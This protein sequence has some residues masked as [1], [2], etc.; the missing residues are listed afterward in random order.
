MKKTNADFIIADLSILHEISSLSFQGSEAKFMEEAGEKAARLFGLR[1]FA[2]LLGPKSDQRLMASLGLRDGKDTEKLVRNNNVNQFSY[3]FGDDSEF[4]T[5]YMEQTRPINNRE[6]RI[7][8]IFARKIEDGIKSA[9][10]AIKRQ[11]AEDALK[12][13]KRLSDMIDF[14]PD[15]TFVID[16]EG[17]VIAW[18]RAMEDMTGIRAADMIGKGNYEYS[19]PFYKKRQPMLVDL[20]LYPDKE[21]EKQYTA[22]QRTKEMLFGEAFSPK[23]PPGN[24]HLSAT[25]SILRNAQGEVI[26]A[27]EC[28]RDNTIRRKLEERVNRAEK[29]EALGTL[30]GGVAHDLNNVLG[31]L[32][33]YSELLLLELPEDNPLRKYVSSILH[34]GQRG[35]AIIQ[36]LLTLARRG[37]AVSEVVNLN[38]IILD[39]FHTPEFEKLKAYHPNVTFKTSLEQKLLNIK[40]SPV[41]LCRTV[42][43]LLSNASEAIV[44]QGEVTIRVENVYI[45]K[46]VRGYDE[47]WEGDYVML[48]VADNG[49]GI[50]PLDIDRIFEPFYTKK[51]MGRSGTG[52]GLAVVWGTVKDHEGYINVESEEEKGS[53]FTLYFPATREDFAPDQQAVSS[54]TYMGRDES[55]LVIDDVKEQRELAA[56]MLSKLGY[57]VQSVASGEEAEEYLKTH[58]MDL[59]LLDMIMDPGIDGLETYQRILKINPQQKAVIVSGFSETDRVR[60]AQ[61]LGAGEYIKKPYLLEKIGLAVNKELLKA[62]IGN[63]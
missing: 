2:I 27:I 5:I 8:K 56:S 17:K 58:P 19:L 35:A 16:R 40:G 43:N 23:L 46:P 61:Q 53:T 57:K 22:M 28:L 10:E 6:Q 47:I 14:L 18:N 45:D 36:D 62:R 7:Y 1:R 55:I 37:V 54:A 59:L 39:Y 11:L 42:M 21:V 51:V 3:N 13:L 52:L 4:G 63:P 44:D 38:K 9:R 41:H 29:M 30:A 26:A 20:A 25:A 24:V 49:R 48:T 34:S 12:E 60:Q 32:V 31:V 50:S 33:G 15:A